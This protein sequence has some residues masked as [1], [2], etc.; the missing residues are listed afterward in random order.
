MHTVQM[1]FPGAD[2]KRTMMEHYIRW[3]L[4][5]QREPDPNNIDARVDAKFIIPSGTPYT[6]K[7][8]CL[9]KASMEINGLVVY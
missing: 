9:N 6:G 4:R 2:K 1:L 8:P 3:V 5:M 7:L